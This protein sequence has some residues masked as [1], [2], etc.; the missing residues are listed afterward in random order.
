MYTVLSLVLP[1]FGIIFIGYLSGRIAKIPI[2]GLAWLNFFIIYIALPALFFQLLAKTPV[3]QFSNLNFIVVTTVST[4]VI[5]WFSF[6]ISKFRKNNGIA[7][8]TIQGF[9]GGYGNIGYMGPPIALLAFGPEAGIPVALVFCFDNIHHF[10]LAPMLMGM[11]DS[12]KRSRWVLIKSI[13]IKIFSHPFIIATILGCLAAVFAFKPPEV[14]ERLLNF[15]QA[16]AA[17]SALFVMGVTAALRPLKRVPFELSYLVP[18]KLVMHPM[19]VYFALIYFMPNI[20]PVWL[21]TAVLMAAL[22]SATNVFVIAQQYDVW[23][24]RASSVV[25]VSTLVSVVTVT[26]YLYWVKTGLI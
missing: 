9:A 11:A 2:S 13:L 6:L 15:L 16:A 12:E 5:F 7:E 20:N 19:L 24:E 8:S 25:V 21:H 1:L 17:P 26:V 3:E 22:P 18:I 14:I 10:T 4:A 23:Q